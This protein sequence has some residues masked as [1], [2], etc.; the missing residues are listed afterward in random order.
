MPK[1][2]KRPR[3]AMQ[4]AKLIGDIAVSK[5]QEPPNPSFQLWFTVILP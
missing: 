3:D 4:L 5:I 1:R 2:P